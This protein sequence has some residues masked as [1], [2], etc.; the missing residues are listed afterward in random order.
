MSRTVKPIIHGLDKHY[1]LELYNV[2]RPEA[3]GEEIIFECPECG[4]EYSFN[5]GHGDVLEYGSFFGLDECHE[6]GVDFENLDFEVSATIKVSL[7][8]K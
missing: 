1:E 6:C 3:F 8:E 2:K 4:Y 5:L 7:K